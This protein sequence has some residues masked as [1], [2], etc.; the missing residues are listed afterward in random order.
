MTVHAHEQKITLTI[1]TFETRYEDG[2]RYLD[3]CGDTL[4]RI[5]QLDRRWVLG[6]AMQNMPKGSAMVN[7]ERELSLFFNNERIAISV[8]AGAGFPLVEG[9]RKAELLGVNGEALYDLIVE[10]IRVRESSRVGVR[11]RF[12]APADSLEEADRFV[13]RGAKSLMLDVPFSAA[14][15]SD[16]TRDAA[17]FF[18]VEDQ[19]TGHRR[20]I[21][22]ESQTVLKPGDPEFTGLDSA[23]GKAAGQHR[24]R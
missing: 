21:A 22:I 16:S 20:R 24:Y 4:V 7:Q 11:Y 19:A 12:T 9:E 2:Y 13:S 5:R 17:L 18:V 8:Q 3:H 6:T 1:A 14:T 23:T 15:R 10:C